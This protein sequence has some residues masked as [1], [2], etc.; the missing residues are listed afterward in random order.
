MKLITII[1]IFF[2]ILGAYYIFS[3]SENSVQKIYPTT[4]KYAFDDLFSKEFKKTVQVFIDGAYAQDPNPEKLVKTI[5]QQFPPLQQITFTVYEQDHTKFIIQGYKPL[6]LINDEFVVLANG[7]IFPKSW[8]HKKFLRELSNV[9]YQSEIKH[10]KVDK[11]FVKFFIACPQEILQNCKII[12][13]SHED[14]A[15]R[16]KQDDYVIIRTNASQVPEIQDLDI[17]KNMKEKMGIQ[18]GN[19]KGKIKATICDIRFSRQ[20][21]VSSE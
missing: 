1:A 8:Y 9:F 15:I 13:K 17:C 14:I 21:V 20:V 5:A 3:R 6:L 16:S 4:C 11:R 12:W 7:K 19:K 2:C 18:R 10:N